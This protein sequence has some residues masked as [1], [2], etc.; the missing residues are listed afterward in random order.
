MEETQYI[1]PTMTIVAVPVR[2]L[3]GFGS[4]GD[5]SDAGDADVRAQEMPTT[6]PFNGTY[7]P[8]KAYW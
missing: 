3:M 6:P 8:L 1:K 5:T 2:V 4:D 7:T